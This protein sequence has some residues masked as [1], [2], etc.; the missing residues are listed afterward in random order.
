MS[1]FS[2]VDSLKRD[3]NASSS[4]TVL[5]L[6]RDDA[7]SILRE[8]EKSLGK[9]K[10]VANPHP[11]ASYDSGKFD[12]YE[13]LKWFVTAEDLR[14][15]QPVTSLTMEG[16]SF[17]VEFFI[18]FFMFLFRTFASKPCGRLKFSTCNTINYILFFS[19]CVRTDS[20]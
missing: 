8:V 13:S 6:I 7:I 12:V 10:T 15:R 18:S 4:E 16:L 5:Q 11:I 20:K 2:Q 3:W 14:N 17:S 19:K 9:E 1:D